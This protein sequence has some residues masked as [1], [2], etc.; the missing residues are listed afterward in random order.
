MIQLDNVSK[1]FEGT[2]VLKNINLTINQGEVVTLIGPS[3]AGKTTLLRLLNWLEV[4]DSGRIT[5]GEVTIDASKYSKHDVR[6]LRGQSSMVFQHYNLFKN[7][8]VLENVTESLVIVSKLKQKEA[9]E[10]AEALLKKV[11][12]GDKLHDYPANLSGGQQQRVGIA[13]ALAVDPKVMLFDE[14][15]SAL[16]P[17][18]VGEILHLIK[19]IA[20]QGMTM[21]LVSHE[22]RF[23]RSVAS[24]IIFLEHG[25]LV[26]DSNPKDLFE[27][28]KSVRTQA[29]L[30]KL[31][32][33]EV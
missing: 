15:T 18:W 31:T 22:M 11:G 24:R 12:M 14:P 1:S 17:E 10:K 6:R 7:K 32:Y 5:V 8:T 9:E 21:I 19:Q 25:E 3:G 29:F 2:Q 13:R 23:V 30:Q 26:E 28:S 4:P 20:A 16:D 33:E 27:N